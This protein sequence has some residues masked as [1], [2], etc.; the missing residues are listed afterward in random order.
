MVMIFF[1]RRDYVSLDVERFGVECCSCSPGV[2][3]DVSLIPTAVVL[4]VR[5]FGRRLGRWFLLSTFASRA[6]YTA[7]YHNQRI[8]DEQ[9]RPLVFQ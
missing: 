3:L 4:V 1:L 2:P 6:A 9:T 5:N 7:Q 8:L